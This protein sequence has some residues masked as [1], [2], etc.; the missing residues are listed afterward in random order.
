MLMPLPAFA[1]D[2]I[3]SLSLCL[4][5]TLYPHVY[6]LECTEIL[7]FIFHRKGNIYFPFW[8]YRTVLSKNIP[9]SISVHKSASNRIPWKS[10][11][12]FV[13]HVL[14]DTGLSGAGS[15]CSIGLHLMDHETE[16][17]GSGC[18]LDILEL[19]RSSQSHFEWKTPKK[20]WDVACHIRS[21]N[22][23]LRS[24]TQ[25][26]CNAPGSRYS[27]LAQA[28]PKKQTEMVLWTNWR[29]FL[30][31]EGGKETQSRIWGSES[32]PAILVNYCNSAW[33][34]VTIAK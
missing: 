6:L 24:Q 11:V 12:F 20:V 9:L 13:Q 33:G 1:S 30:E 27:R 7:L 29:L 34:K 23:P 10:W 15:F 3:Y 8:D 4:H 19:L 16:G 18:F 2:L 26:F 32:Y 14:E 21:G 5:V 28:L 25:T 22:S 31:F 17:Q